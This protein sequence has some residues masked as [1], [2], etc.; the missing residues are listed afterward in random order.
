MTAPVNPA[1]KDGDRKSWVETHAGRGLSFVG[2]GERLTYGLKTHGIAKT[3]WLAATAPMRRALVRLRY[4]VD[5]HLDR[6]YGTDTQGRIALAALGFASENKDFG[7]PYEPTPERSFHAM[8]AHLPRSLAAFTFVD[9]GCGKGR[10]LLYAARYDFARILGV[11]LA[12][13]LAAIAVANAGK[14]A[15]A[16]GDGRLDIDC[17][18]ATRFTLPP[19]P[20]V[21]YLF[22]PFAVEELYRAFAELVRQS[23]SANPRKV[24]VVLYNAGNWGAGFAAS[25]FLSLAAEG[26]VRFDIGA[27][28]RYRYAIFETRG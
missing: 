18:D 27:P 25:G 2:I 28:A 22:S 3:L 23:V 14:F 6:R 5:G 8:M 17:A 9:V 15:A 1:K 4:H 12:P 16:T 7:Q 24:Y 10:T 26:R 11:E 13:E 21:C 20:L 19:T